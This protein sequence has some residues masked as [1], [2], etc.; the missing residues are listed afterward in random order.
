MTNDVTIQPTGD[1]GA[2]PTIDTGGRF[3][4]TAEGDVYLDRTLV[5][6]G[7]ST[8]TRN[9]DDPTDLHV[10]TSDSVDGP[11]DHG[12]M[13]DAREFYTSSEFAA[14]RDFAEA[15]TGWAGPHD[16]TTT[17]GWAILSPS[18]GVIEPWYSIGDDYALDQLGDDPMNPEHWATAAGR[19]RPDGQ[20]I[21]TQRDH[22]AAKVATGLAKWLAG[23]REPGSDPRSCAAKSLLVVASEDLVA[24]L[25]DRGVFEYGIARM[26]GNP[27]E[28]FTLP[29]HSRF[30]C[31][32][33]DDRL[34]WLSDAIGRHDGESTREGTGQPELGAWTGQRRV[35][36][37]C[38]ATGHDAADLREFGGDVYC[39]DCE[40]VGR[41]NRCDEWTHETGLGRYPLCADCQTQY[42][43]QKSIPLEDGPGHEQGTLETATDGGE[44]R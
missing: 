36:L 39:G 12:P 5:L 40:P 42:G 31:D 44:Q 17:A 25:R 21:V 37:E 34:T 29:V 3:R 23:H 10:A 27:N 7:A 2:G 43:G 13:W 35:C 4:D 26:T 28:G 22:W 16:G 32:E 9:P 20:E 15:V 33:V 24:P 18:H 30:L 1:A 8:E 6:V 14:E 11:R 41:C 38:G 19:R